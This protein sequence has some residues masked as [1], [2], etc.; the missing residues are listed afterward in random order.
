M[1]DI[2]FYNFD[3][4]LIATFPRVTSVNFQKNYCGFGAAEI[5]FSI[6]EKDV[7]YMLEKNSYLF[8]MAGKNSAVVT[9][10]RIGEDIAVFGRTPEWLLT[11]RGVQAFESK[12]ATAEDIARNA[13]QAAA[14]DFV[15]LGD[16]AGLGEN[17]SY[18]T[19]GVRVLHDVVCEVLGSQEL[20]FKVVPD[21]EKKTFVFS[22]FSG[23][24]ALCMVSPS[25]RTAYDLEYTVEK[26][27]MVTNSGWYERKFVDMGGWD[28]YNNSPSLSDKQSSNAYTFYEITSETYYQSGSKYYPVEVFGLNCPKGAYLYSDTPDGKWKITYTKPDTIWIYIGNSGV[29]GARRW[30]AVLSGIKTETEATA[31]ISQMTR[32]DNTRAE[33]KSIEYDK[34]Y[35]LGDIVRVQT[36][37]GEFKK[38]EKKRVAA[39]NIYYDVDK[40]GVVPTLKRLEE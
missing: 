18:S 10:W 35:T 11:K 39:V 37:F 19:D 27:D 12:L 23:Q 5:H 8:F 4:T 34:D 20:G 26:Q 7:I 9:G 14:G 13:V 38:S 22:V 21:I 36:E 1:T 17:Q 30:D 33:V 25:Y 40:F 16:I 32:Q 28:A 29:S 15:T 6:N 31:E 3:F 24:E 2:N